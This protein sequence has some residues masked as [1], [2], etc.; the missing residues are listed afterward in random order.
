MAC[1]KFR[2]PCDKCAFADCQDKCPGV[3][4]WNEFCDRPKVDEDKILKEPIKKTFGKLFRS[5]QKFLP[6]VNFQSLSSNKV[7]TL[8]RAEIIMLLNAIRL[9]DKELVPP[10]YVNLT[11]ENIGKMLYKVMTA[12]H[13]NRE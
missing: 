9:K 10:D 1:D 12:I 4:F 6:E 13:E 2:M 5:L 8:K 11:N 7:S 3:N